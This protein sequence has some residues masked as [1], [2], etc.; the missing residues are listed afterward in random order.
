MLEEEPTEETEI[1]PE[2]EKIIKKYEEMLKEEEQRTELPFQIRSRS[3]WPYG[4]T[5]EIKF[6]DFRVFNELKDKSGVGLTQATSDQFTVVSGVGLTQG[7]SDQ[8]IQTVSG[9]VD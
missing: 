7:T 6:W 9:E 8:I 5:L 2:T 3:S 1:T 4:M